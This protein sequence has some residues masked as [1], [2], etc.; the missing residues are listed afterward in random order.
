MA[1]NG[2]TTTEGDAVGARIREARLAANMSV[3]ELAR[4]M[5]VSPSHVSQVERGIA[6]FSV[7]ALYTVVGVLDV[8][9]DS[10]FED[11]LRSPESDGAA[12]PPRVG[13]GEPD[14]LVEARVVQRADAR[15]AIPLQGGTRWERLT[16]RAEPVVEFIE[17]VYPPSAGQ[18]PPDDMIRHAGREYG[19]VTHGTLTV[20][21]GFERTA[22]APGDSIA[23]DSV[24]P[25]RFW[26]DT[27]HE[28]RAVWVIV[29]GP[30]E[31][32]SGTAGR[33]H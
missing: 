1:E 20:Q 30:D 19:V 32:A 31:D 11:P 7:R 21:V 28:V 17:V 14:P 26:N 4:R 10:L 29:D 8:S 24:T 5:N 22:L 18:P 16:P 9:M 27:P 2:S 3:R 6:S 15:A 12:T 25:H 23:F 33:G 13:P